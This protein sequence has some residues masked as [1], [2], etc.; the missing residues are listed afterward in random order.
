M[1]RVFV[2]LLLAVVSSSWAGVAYRAPQ[3]VEPATWLGRDGDAI[4]V[5]F[6]L[7]ALTVDN[8]VVDGFGSASLFRVP[9]AGYAFEIGSPDLPAIRRMILV[10][11]TGGYELEI[12]S[13]QTSI[14]GNYSV[15]PCQPLPTRDGQSSPYRID[16]AVYD[17]DQFYPGEAAT[18]EGM[19]V[20]RDIRVAWVRFNPVRYNPVTGETMLTTSVVVR[21]V[22]TG[23]P[24]ENE[25]VRAA[26]GITPEFLP[27]YE[28]VLGFDPTGMRAVDGC[29]LVLGTTAS[30]GLCQDLIDWKREKGYQVEFGVV[31]TIGSTAAAIDTW[32]ENAYN[33]WPNPPLW[34]LI[35]GDNT[36]VPTTMSGSTAQDNRYGCIGTTCAPSIH[37]G[38]ICNQ[39]TNDLAYQTWKIF[40][41]E[42]DPYMPTPSW[43]QDAISIGSTDFSDPEHSWEYAVI[44]MTAGM[45]VD[46]FC[47]EGGSPPTVAN[48][49]ASINEGTSLI[50]Y[51]GHGDTQYWVTSGFSNND[52]ANLT[53]GRKLP[54]VNSIACYNAAFTSAYCFGEAWMNE[55]SIASPKGAIGFMGATTASPVGQTDTLADFTFRGYFEEDIW[56]MG[57]A[58]D[59]GKMK[60][61]EFYGEGGAAS[62]NNMH[63]V[64]G[65]P[66]TDIFTETSPLPYLV[67]AHATTISPGAFPVTVTCNGTPV[68]N[69]LVGAVQDTTYLDG[70][71]TNASGVATLTIPGGTLQPTPWVTIT[72]TYHNR[73]PYRGSANP[74]TGIGDGTSPAVGTWL[75]TPAPS[76]FTSS[77]AV[78]FSTPGGITSLAV[79]DMSG[80]IVRTLGSGASEAGEYSLTWD[81]RDDSGNQ[82]GAG[83]YMVRLTTPDGSISR[84][85]VMLR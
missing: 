71:Y 53:N 48:I 22:P 76:P 67:G 31:P 80:R 32:I 65:C 64:F 13:E 42:Y 43:F 79:Y 12:V 20:L 9:E 4:L 49:A 62:N 40:N 35:C 2:L 82:L 18:L 84:S 37:V 73:V 57:A 28:D 47:D 34:I 50:S 61:V 60:V 59:Y 68:Q 10:D 77:T 46:Y 70:A 23:E 6:D 78:G 21:L 16:R 29:Y 5:E 54:W 3:A 27:W 55:G 69:A 44:F 14:L 26:Q 15:A 24:G 7:Q 74:G 81:G 51:I 41:Y 75:A 39:D 52:V 1:G 45:T 36:Q 83:V 85:C 66:E 25:F 11:N 63:M 38:R 56:H 30:I 58:V 72:A 17:S 33:T 8:S 19:Q